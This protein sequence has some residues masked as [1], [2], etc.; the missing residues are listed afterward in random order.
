MPFD[1]NDVVCR[2]FVED[3]G[4]PRA[5]LVN[6]GVLRP[7]SMDPKTS[8]AEPLFDLY[9]PRKSPG[10]QGDY[11]RPLGFDVRVD[12]DVCMSAAHYANDEGKREV[13]LG[14]CAHP[15]A[16]SLRLG[17]YNMYCRAPGALAEALGIVSRGGRKVKQV[18]ALAGLPFVIELW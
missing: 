6:S 17:P 12:I 2:R 15:V 10:I 7:P 5:S 9:H 8:L 3:L 4:P 14:G 18:L 1:S 11:S 16:L 13:D